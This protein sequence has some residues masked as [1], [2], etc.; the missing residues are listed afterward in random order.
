MR[1]TA[2]IIS[3]NTMTAADQFNYT[4][5]IVSAIKQWQII[6]A[7]GPH[8]IN[9]IHVL[10]PALLICMDN[11]RNSSWKSIDRYLLIRELITKTKT[12]DTSEALLD[13]LASTKQQ[14]LEKDRETDESFLYS[15]L[16]WRRNIKGSSR[17]LDQIDTMMAG[18]TAMMIAEGKAAMAEA[19]IEKSNQNMLHS[20]MRRKEERSHSLYT[21]L[22][23]IESSATSYHPPLLK[24]QHSLK[25]V[26]YAKHMFAFYNSFYR[27]EAFREEIRSKEPSSTRLKH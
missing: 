7:K 27:V 1:Q 14:L 10:K 26:P 16:G 20:L 2:A 21:Q 12:I 23:E 4:E 15:L 13:L 24:A 25:P 8:K 18:V 6:D 11:Y 3:D 17:L 9:Y 22:K 5:N 19:C